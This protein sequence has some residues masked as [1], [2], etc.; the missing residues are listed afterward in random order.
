MRVVSR[1]TATAWLGGGLLLVAGW[2]VVGA[3]PTRGDVTAPFELEASLNEWAAGRNLTAQVIEVRF[4]DSIDDGLW[5]AEGNWL[6]FTLDVA[7]VVDQTNAGL[8]LTELIVDGVQYDATERTTMTLRNEPLSPGLA[9]RGELAFELPD[10]VV[11][12][13][14]QL[15]LAAASDPQLDSII[16]ID[17][18]LSQLDRLDQ[19]ELNPVTWSPQ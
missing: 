7:A 12:G 5:H 18:D 6:V 16:V 14:A 15:R 2:F 9:V 1:S 4:A 8:Y 10:D 19:I 13:P 11:D 17:V 3:T